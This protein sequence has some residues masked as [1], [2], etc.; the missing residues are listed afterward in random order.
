[1][2]GIINFSLNN[3]FAIWILTIIISFA[4]L[5]S[6]MTM[7]Q[8]TIP[9]I[10]VPFLNVTAI[11]P[12]AAR[13]HCRRCNQTAG[14]EAPQSRRCE[15][16]HFHFHGECGIHHAGIR[17][18]NGPDERNRYRSRSTERGAITGQCTETNHF[19]IQY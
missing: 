9:N 12:G 7:K 19:Q 5:Y 13:G 6:G 8:E 10:N 1:M 14:T 16:H 11:D 15:N 4:G 18:W 17:L 2:K 3:K